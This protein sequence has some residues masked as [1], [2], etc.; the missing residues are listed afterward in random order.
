M[1]AAV[2]SP[3]VRVGFSNPRVEFSNFQS[4]PGA[5]QLV[6]ASVRANCK[7]APEDAE[8]ENVNMVNQVHP[9]I[10]QT[11]FLSLQN[12]KNQ[13]MTTNVWVEQYQVSQQSHPPLRANSVRSELQPLRPCPRRTL[14]SS[15]YAL[16]NSPYHQISFQ[17][18]G[19]FVDKACLRAAGAPYK[20]VIQRVD[21]LSRAGKSAGKS[22][23]GFRRPDATPSSGPSPGRC[24]IAKI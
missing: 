22:I 19:I 10:L 1:D 17:K 11:V 12:L 5:P 8:L 20:R 21:H 14:I 23:V 7:K 16:V 18:Y 6:S 24:V 9:Q 2:S 4:A 13:I 15:Y 3:E